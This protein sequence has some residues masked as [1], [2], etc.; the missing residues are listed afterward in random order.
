MNTYSFAVRVR[1]RR[2]AFAAIRQDIVS[3]IR[4]LEPDL[5]DLTFANGAAAV[6]RGTLTV[7]T[8]G[9]HDLT[10]GYARVCLE[11]RI[12][13]RH[14]TRELLL[15]LAD[16]EGEPGGVEVL[17]R[18]EGLLAPPPGA[19]AA[20]QRGRGP[21]VWARKLL[22]RWQKRATLHDDTGRPIEPVATI[23]SDEDFFRWASFVHDET[24]DRCILA[25]TEP[26]APA[27][28]LP[29]E[30]PLLA[31]R[32]AGLAHVLFIPQRYTRTWRAQLGEDLAV[33]KGAQRLYAPPTYRRLAG[34]E[35][36]AFDVHPLVHYKQACRL[37]ADGE[38]FGQLIPAILSRQAAALP[39]EPTT[40][41]R[42]YDHFR[43][44]D[45]DAASG[46]QDLDLETTQVLY[47]DLLEIVDALRETNDD[48]AA[49]LA[50]LAPAEAA[51]RTAEPGLVDLL[52]DAFGDEDETLLWDT[53][54]DAADKVPRGGF[55]R[56]TVDRAFAAVAEYAERLAGSPT[57]TLDQPPYY[58]FRN[59]GVAYA[60]SESMTTMG[61]YGG[62]RTF[63]RGGEERIVESH[64][65]LNPNTDRCLHLYLDADREARVVHVVYCGRHLPHGKGTHNN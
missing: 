22:A 5:P 40:Y 32:L 9:R 30:T 52:I 48:L 65:T 23:H 41:A 10:H 24:R 17:M 33:F 49:R 35:A 42:A 29:V 14:A 47:A 31:R 51:E 55:N 4:R 39:S 61:L 43:A 13:A 16:R 56:R 6:Q 57:F 25:V 37:Y 8:E 2:R 50:A 7:E 1:I 20:S 19:D 34:R 18:G 38:L 27:G 45:L 12:G 58:F 59:L 28:P 44:R 64:L 62:A 3:A 15:G 26:F 36:T 63:R 46:A 54:A 21:F 11:Q 60:A 53:A